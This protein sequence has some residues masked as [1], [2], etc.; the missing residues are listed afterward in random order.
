MYQLQTVGEIVRLLRGRRDLEQVELARACGWRDASAVSRI[1][2]DRI[3][4]TRKTLIKLAENLADG[5]AGG[6]ASDVRAWL[7]F[8]AGILPTSDD[9][10]RVEDSLPSIEG[11]T[12]PAVVM[13]FGWNIWRV[14]RSFEGFLSLPA[15]YRGQNLFRILFSDQVRR[16][17][18]DSWE[19][20]ARE[21]IGQF[22]GETDHRT[23]QR[24]HRALLSEMDLRPD[25]TRIW[26]EVTP[27]PPTA[28]Q[29]RTRHSASRGDVSIVRMTLHS[30]PRLSL[31]HIVLGES[32]APAPSEDDRVRLDE[33]V[34]AGIN[35][36]LL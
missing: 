4:P 11:W 26:R 3:H 5:S 32:A 6:S 13:D 17:L 23:G 28:L 12:Q 24:W 8:A 34:R 2:T 15:D 33:P 9:F 31:T 20:F 18:G 25:F 36:G 1:E 10:A 21:S 30:D 22:R 27:A 19:G 29:V 35:T 16:Q 7:F 14:N